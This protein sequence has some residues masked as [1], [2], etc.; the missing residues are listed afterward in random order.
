[1]AANDQQ[2]LALILQAA[3]AEYPE[4]SKADFFEQ[5]CAEQ[6]LK[7]YDLSIEDIQRGIV[8]GE[9]DGGADSVY[10]FV[11]GELIPEDNFDL[12]PFKKDVS[13]EL[14]II[15][16]KSA[17]GFNEGTIDKLISLASA[18]LKI[19]ADYAAI[20]QYNEAVK[21]VM[22]GFREVYTKLVNKF[23]SLTINYYYAAQKADQ[24]VH[25]NTQI[26]A[27]SLKA[28]TSEL[29]PEAVVTFNFIAA[30][31]LVELARRKPRTTFSLQTNKIVGSGRGYVSLVT[32]SAYNAFL[33]DD[34]G[35]LNRELFESN[36]RDFQGST[37]VNDDIMATLKGTSAVDFWE[38]NNG[39]TIL[40]SKA[41]LNGD[42][43]IIENPQ[44]VNGLQTSSQI[45]S[46][47][48]GGA[49][50]D[51]RQ[52]MIKVVAFDDEETRDKIIKATNFQNRVEPASLRATDKVQRD[53]E[54]ALR[55]NG[56]FYDRRKNFYKNLGKPAAKI[57]SIPLLA[58]ATMSLILARPDN[59]RAR[60]SSLLKDDDT[61]ASVFS[62][63]IPVGAYV[64]A[65][66]LLQRVDAELRVYP[67]IVRRERTN[68]RFFVLYWLGAEQTRRPNPAAAHIEKVDIAK[69]T[70][71]EIKDAIKTVSALYHQA[72]ASD[73]AAKGTAL[74][75]LVIE[76]VKVAIIAK[77]NPGKA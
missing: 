33:R 2:V 32:L 34:H 75:D 72:G 10:A 4:Q 21:S 3:H 15:Q 17:D 63:K 6:I 53:I 43:V 62:D 51:T 60:P 11:N 73:Q 8:D 28:Q 41:I 13:I 70:D 25:Q 5:F 9:H 64:K 22:N 1:M 35:K 37:E 44:I 65:A 68:I 47:F 12:T 76:K 48:D 56:L 74:R 71:A 45:A 69:I 20:P 55:A 19:N 23:P 38:M 77:M 67:G 14:H 31:K 50:A 54:E 59:A 29:F 18:L 46:Y 39:V 36:V 7:D 58:Q 49:P 42:T 16:S 30:P 57:I 40:S 24:H 66:L 61:Y 52:V 26:K 27:D